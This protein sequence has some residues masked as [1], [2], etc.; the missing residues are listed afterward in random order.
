MDA[1]LL[2]MLHHRP[3]NG[4]FAIGHAVDIDLGGVL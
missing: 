4:I 2:N 3:N 1:C